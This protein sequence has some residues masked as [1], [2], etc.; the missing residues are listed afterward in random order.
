MAEKKYLL[1]RIVKIL[2]AIFLFVSLY[3]VAVI[4]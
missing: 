1:F 2:K 4:F 3:L